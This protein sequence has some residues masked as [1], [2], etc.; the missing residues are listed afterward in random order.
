MKEASGDTSH[1]VSVGKDITHIIKAAED[2]NKMKLARTVQQKLY[3][4]CAPELEHFDLAGAAYPAD[5]TG[6]D[7]FDYLPMQ[8]ESLCIAIGDVSG[9]GI[10]TALVMAQT[11]AYLRSIAA[12]RS[13]VDDILRSL[14]RTLVTDKIDDHYVTMLLARLNPRTGILVYSNAGHPTGY[15]L[16]GRGAVK[17]AL[18]STS[19]PLGLFL[20][21]D[22]GPRVEL[23]LEPGD[24]VVLLT[25]GV[26]ETENKKGDV[27]GVDRALEFI[28]SHR[29]EAAKDIVRGLYQSVRSF[30]GDAQQ[31][32][33][34]TAIVCKVFA[35]S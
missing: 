8:D 7:C 13:G 21:L 15:I 30:A 16:D 12:S 3:P 32:D 14:N 11:R 17:S 10:A 35:S 29:H 22:C 27:F 19:I 2:E 4:S 6:G 25:D 28:R 23:S 31:N 34:M 26:S 33:D 24:L 9:H 18:S 20:E 5:A 1:F